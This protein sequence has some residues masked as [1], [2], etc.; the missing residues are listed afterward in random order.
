[1]DIHTLS[2]QSLFV[3]I[4]GKEILHGISLVMKSGEVHVLM[5][6]NGG[7]KS[8]FAYAIAGH[9][10]YTIE[11]K[12]RQDN[13]VF[14]D[15]E[16]LNEMPA[17]SRARKGIFLAFQAPMAIEGVSVVNLLRTAY[18]NLY[19]SSDKRLNR[20]SPHNPV[21]KR[22]FHAADKSLAEFIQD[23]KEQCG[24]IQIPESFLK[25]SIHDGFSGGEKKKLEMLQ[26]LVL[27][28]KF[29]LFDEIDTGLDVDAL[30][31]VAQS[32][33]NLVKRGTGVLLVT[34][35]QRILR[36]IRPDRVHVMLNGN[37]VESGSWSL[38][39]KIETKGYAM[40]KE[41]TIKMKHRETR[42]K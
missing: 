33:R 4:E 22:R 25:R 31:V 17:D 39:K 6:P 11:T 30:K 27:K 36:H 5:G 38:A 28:P 12:G 7:G 14:L 1:M 13:G 18:Q 35:Y 42:R 32:I 40:Y 19:P 41:D 3:S 2:A 10:H 37:I 29:A 34:H 16:S 20:D 21:L 8:T 24:V 26:A 9:P 15:N 23:I